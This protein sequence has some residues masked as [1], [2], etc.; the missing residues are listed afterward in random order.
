MRYK[1][2]FDKTI[3]QLAPHYLSGRRF[4]LYLQAIM[5]P[6]QKVNDAFA[7]WAQETR[8]EASMS[9]QVIHFEWFLNRRYCKY[10]VDKS[11][12]IIIAEVVRPGVYLYSEDADVAARLHMVLKHESEGGEGPVLYHKSEQLVATDCSFIVS[13]PRIDTNIITEQEYVSMLKHTI[14]RYRLSGK[15]YTIQFN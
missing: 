7:S 1:I 9:S 15:T 10:F 3:N 5:A 6:L 4:I 14:N 11:E 13:S 8:I 2:N 12:K